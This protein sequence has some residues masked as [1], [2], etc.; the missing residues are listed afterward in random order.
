M[1]LVM[2]TERGADL[3]GYGGKI[4]RSGSDDG[5]RWRRESR[6][7]QEFREGSRDFT[8]ELFDL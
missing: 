1:S 6:K 4:F 3:R 2:W 7:W 8:I 5:L